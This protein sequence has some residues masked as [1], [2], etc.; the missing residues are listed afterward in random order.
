MATKD[1]VWVMLTLAGS[2][3]GVVIGQAV[4]NTAL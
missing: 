3:A 4:A 2:A 1:I